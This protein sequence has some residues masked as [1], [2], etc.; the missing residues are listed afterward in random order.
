[1]QSPL[2]WLKYA[3]YHLRWNKFTVR[4]VENLRTRQEYFIMNRRLANKYSSEKKLHV[5]IRFFE[6]KEFKAKM[7]SK[8]AF[9]MI[10]DV[11]ADMSSQTGI[12]QWELRER[13]KNDFNIDI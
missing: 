7:N 10:G 5:M 1:M 8:M 6:M 12:P 2:W 9:R 3:I 13:I 4:F 11:I